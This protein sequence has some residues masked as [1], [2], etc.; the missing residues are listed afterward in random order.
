MYHALLQIDDDQVT[1]PVDVTYAE[2]VDTL[3]S[4]DVFVSISIVPSTKMVYGYMPVMTFRDDDGVNQMHF[5]T[6]H[7][8]PKCAL[9]DVIC[10]GIDIILKQKNT[11]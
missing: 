9:D 4:F 11:L 6:P 2:I 1:K 10:R 8:F 5:T 3:M 7:F